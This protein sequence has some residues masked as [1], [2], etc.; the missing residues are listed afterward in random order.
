M[1]LRIIPAYAGST[2]RTGRYGRPGRD[3]PRIRGEHESSTS[4]SRP[5]PGSSPHTRGARRHASRQSRRASDHPRIRGEHLIALLPLWLML[6]SSPHT[7]GAPLPGPQPAHCGRIIPAYAG[8]TSMTWR[9]R[10]PTPDH[11]R[12]RGEHRSSTVSGNPS[13]G[14][15]P[16]TRGART[17]AV[18]EAVLRRIIP[19]Y[20]GS[21]DKNFPNLV[22]ATD[23]P[24]IRGEHGPSD[25]WPGQTGGSS[26]HT[27]GARAEGVGVGGVAGIIPAY[28]GSTSAACRNRARRGDHPRIRGEHD[29]SI[30]FTNFPTGS[31]PH[32]RGARQNNIPNHRRVDGSS[33]HTRGARRPVDPGPCACRIIPAYAGSTSF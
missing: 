22:L 30:Y 20:A 8:S 21:T 27:R 15:S 24:R 25:G 4:R 14:S 29:C 10:R 18:R 17:Q 6:G 13:H 7:R 31:S 26:P 16:H 1:A 9:R 19:A 3:H 23:H 5:S 28:A 12:I 11:P 32:T 2:P 33:P